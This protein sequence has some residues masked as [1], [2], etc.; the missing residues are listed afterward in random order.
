MTSRKRK[1]GERGES[2]DRLQCEGRK[3]VRG[4][5]RTGGSVRGERVRSQLSRF[6]PLTAD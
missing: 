1:G 2:E 5:R 6:S 3:G 4:E